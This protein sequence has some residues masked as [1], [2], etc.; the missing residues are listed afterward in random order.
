M[1]FTAGDFFKDPLPTADVIVFG[2]I[3]HNWDLATKTMLLQKA[4]DALPPAGAAIVY[5]LLIDDDR[6]AEPTGLLS[7]LNM[8][9]WTA[10]GF[11]YTGADCVGW[12]RETGFV[13]MRVEKLPG[14]HSMIVGNRA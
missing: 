4:Y 5:D 7:S 9:L 12:M 1:S 14:G 6:S 8:L 10:A 3:L 2:R 11:G 13:G